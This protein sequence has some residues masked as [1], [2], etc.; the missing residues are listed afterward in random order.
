MKS[1]LVL[2]LTSI[3]GILL[4]TSASAATIS[5]T[6]ETDVSINLASQLIDLGPGT[7]DN[8]RDYSD[9]GG[10]VGQTF[11]VTSAGT[12]SVVSIMGRGDSAHI[13]NNGLQPFT[14]AEVWQIQVGTENVDGSINVLDQETATGFAGPVGIA[15]FLNFSLANPVA[16]T[17]GVTYTWSIAM[18]NAGVPGNP[19]FGFA[20]SIGDA[21]ADGTAFNNNTSIVSVDD[22]SGSVPGQFGG[23]VA[24]NPNGYDYVFAVGSVPEPTTAVLLGL[25]GGLALVIFRRRA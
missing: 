6:P 17:P 16:V 21:Y 23:F 20:H 5:E 8:H 7:K 12:I 11:Q 9:N 22:N 2:T 18:G 25:G 15:D 19:W 10:P 3:A 13:W 4:V 24:P 1:T 14:G